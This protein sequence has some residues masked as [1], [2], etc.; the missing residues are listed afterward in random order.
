MK[1]TAWI[2]GMGIVLMLLAGMIWQFSRS[3]TQEMPLIGKTVLATPMQ[4]N[5]PVTIDTFDSNGQPVKM[6]FIKPPERVIADRVNTLGVL[7]ALGQGDKVVGTSGAE[8]P[9][10]YEALKKKFPDE[11]AKVKGSQGFALDLETVLSLQPDFIMGW[12]STFAKDR[13]RSTQWWNNQ[14]VNTYI[15][16]T[17]NHVLPHGTI[18][19]ECRY[20]R[21]IGAVFGVQERAQQYIDEIHQTIENVQERTKGRP[22]QVVMMV[23][24]SR[25]DIFN[26]DDGWI[27]GDMVRQMGGVMPV[28]GRKLSAE[29]LIEIDP[30]VILVDYFLEGQKAHVQEVFSDPRFSSLKAVQQGRIVLIPFDYM[31]APGIQTIDGIRLIRNGLYPDMAE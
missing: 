23:E 2:T 14:G 12:K 18:E 13:F 3:D 26:Y 25:K 31:Y 29:Q 30:D 9:L 21:D 15:I 11:M 24:A 7:L 19:D 16:A 1:K 28:K 20:I 6:T 5:F 27:I 4:G 8:S 10:T 17:S 22:K